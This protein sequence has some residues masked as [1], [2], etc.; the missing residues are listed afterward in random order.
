M[1]RIALDAELSDLEHAGLAIGVEH[2]ADDPTEEVVCRVR[3]RTRIP[4]YGFAG[5]L[6]R[7]KYVGPRIQVA[8]GVASTS[9]RV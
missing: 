7:A 9:L 4:R 3:G 5:W 2:E 1:G 8:V 6:T